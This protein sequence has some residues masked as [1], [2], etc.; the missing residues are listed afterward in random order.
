M[1]SSRLVRLLAQGGHLRR[2][3]ETVSYWGS[4]RPARQRGNTRAM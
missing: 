4:C 2:R 1:I 3:S